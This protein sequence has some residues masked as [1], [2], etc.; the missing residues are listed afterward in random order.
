MNGLLTELKRR[1]VVQVGIAYLVVA[2]GVAQVADLVLDNYGA[3]TWIMQVILAALGIGFPVALVLSWIFDL[4]WDGLHRESDIVSDIIVPEIPVQKVEHE[5]I[6][7][8]PFVN[9]S[10]D[11]EQ[12]YFSDGI[13]EELLNLLA[14]ITELTVI[15]RTSS[16]S[17]KGANKSIAEIG[18]ILRV[19][20]VLEG[21]VRKAG[22]RVRITAQLIETSN[23]SHLWSETYERDL[24]DIFAIQD[25]ISAAI[26]RELK[27]LILGGQDIKAPHT[28]RT[29]N[30]DAYEH[31]LLGQ[32]FL[33][34]RTRDDINLG[35]AHFEK[36]LERDPSFAPAMVGLADAHL[37]LVR[38][39]NGLT[40]PE[41]ALE[42]ATGLLD[43]ALELQG[44]TAETYGVRSEYF[45]LA[46]DL[47]AA[48]EQ[49]EK[50]IALNPN[51]SRGYGVK[52]KALILMGDPDA[53]VLSTIRMAVERDPTSLVGLANLNLQYLDRL[54]FDRSEAILR[55]MV[56]IDPDERLISCC[57]ADTMLYKG[58]YKAALELL[59]TDEMAFSDGI[60]TSNTQ[61]VATDLGGGEVFET[62]NPAW[63]LELYAW[64]GHLGDARRVGPSVAAADGAK[65][66]EE[67][68]LAVALWQSIEGNH[69]VALSWL[70]SFDEADTDKWGAHFRHAPNYMGATLSLY[71]FRRLGKNTSARFYLGKFK[72]LHSILESDPDGQRYSTDFVAAVIAAA[73][74]DMSA[75]IDALEHQI[76]RT[77]FQ[78]AGFLNHPLFE[79]LVNEPR[80]RALLTRVE[81]HIARERAAAETAGLLPI[82]VELLARLK[83]N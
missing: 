66:D 45:R 62:F 76:E 21:S 68:A 5:S 43:H 58:Q 41:E 1:H 55:Q 67:V 8:L 13:S 23:S 36:V 53:P 48:L 37:L 18:T 10:S 42:A 12:E 69:E 74:G 50:A 30:V 22:N 71:L 39:S 29:S 16:F 17:F 40:P 32:H 81:A 54:E 60:V 38:V 70:S 59:L 77:M 64:T 72:E 75:A 6:A 63:A 33:N 27:G 31:Y 4:R 65:E 47:E 51:Y 14:R 56:A 80:Y 44:D 2:W 20:Y 46:G 11:P 24:D 28:K 15:A 78:A 7:V 34:K 61:G 79:D 35:K 82:P 52:A 57:H 26:V 73:E 49:A 9:M 19:A 83:N 25:E 3:P